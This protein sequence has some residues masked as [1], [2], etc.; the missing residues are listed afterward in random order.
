MP[1]ERVVGDIRAGRLTAE[2]CAANFADP[3]RTAE[4]Q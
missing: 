2:Q 4:T 3:R 1:E